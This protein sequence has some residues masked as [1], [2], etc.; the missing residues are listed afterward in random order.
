MKIGIFGGTF[1]PVHTGH[2]IS[3]VEARKTLKLDKVIFIPAFQSP[4][5]EEPGGDTNRLQMLESAVEPYPYFEIDTF[6][7]KNKGLS[8]TY[9]TVK[10]LTK[11]YAGDELYFLIG[12][13][14]YDNFDKWYRYQSLLEMIHFAVM[15]RHDSNAVIL[16]PFIDVGQ[17]V[18]E[19]SSTD[20]RH[21]IKKQDEYRHL[22]PESVY[23]YIKENNLYE[24]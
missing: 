11:K 14:Q 16:E 4:H 12:T 1:D 23:G 3:A 8:Y 13:D 19:I 10:Y 21:R 17:P 22:L 15:R 20:I 24:T 7:L 5:K 6:E 9:D 2:I 18:I